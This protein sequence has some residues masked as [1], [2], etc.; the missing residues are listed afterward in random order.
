MTGRGCGCDQ[1][2]HPD[3]HR[4]ALLQPMA[5]KAVLENEVSRLVMRPEDGILVKRVEGIVT[6]PFGNHPDG[7]ELRFARIG[8]TWSCQRLWSITKSS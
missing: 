2:G 3:P 6:G 1:L 5:G 7:F 4:R 8:Q